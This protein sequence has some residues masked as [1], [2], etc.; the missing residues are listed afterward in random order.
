MDNSLSIERKLFYAERI[1]AND[2]SIQVAQWQAKN[3]NFINAGETIAT[4][5]TSKSV[6]DLQA[7]ASGYFYP[8]APEGD[9]VLIGEP[10]YLITSEIMEQVSL[11]GIGIVANKQENSKQIRGT[12]KAMLLLEKYDLDMSIFSGFN[13]TVKTKDVIAYIDSQKQENNIA[14]HDLV[15]DLYPQVKQKRILLIGA[16]NGSA[17]A[18]DIINQNQHQRAVGILDDASSVSVK[19]VMGIP[20][21]GKTERIEALFEEGYFEQLMICF[22]KNQQKR[23]EIF[24]YYKSKGIPFANVID[25]SAK[26][27]SNVLLGEGNM[28]CAN[29]RVG[30][31]TKIGDNNFISAFTNIEHHNVLGSHI[32]FGP[33]VSTSGSVT[34]GDSIRVGT[35]IFIEPCISIGDGA[36]LASG[37]TITRDIPS[38]CIA[39]SK[40]TVI[41]SPI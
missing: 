19:S 22:S 18:L 39:K 6:T 29:T 40:E 21:M 7:L 30:T 11:A 38:K 32:T 17:V 16:G 20:L 1:N 28:I 35:G 8:I 14:N 25:P 2:E 9:D 36:I 33:F 4:V 23:A 5:E 13:R 34:F 24:S 12:K 26:L 27:H 3:G 37:L 41:V 15:D 10:L 31:C